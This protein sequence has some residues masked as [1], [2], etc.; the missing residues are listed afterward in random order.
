LPSGSVK[1]F[2]PQ[3]PLNTVGAFVMVK[4]KNL[5]GLSDDETLLYVR[6]ESVLLWEALLTAQF[7]GPEMR[8][9]VR[10][11]EPKSAGKGKMKSATPAP[12]NLKGRKCKA[13]A[14][15]GSK[16][17][18][19][20]SVGGGGGADE[21][22]AAPA[23]PP[24]KKGRV[25]A[26]AENSIAEGATAGLAAAPAGGGC[27][28]ADGAP[29]AAAGCGPAGGGCGAAD[30]A[31]V[32]GG[33]GGGGSKQMN[34]AVRG[35]PGTG[36][37]TEVWAWA[38]WMAKNK[39]LQVVWFH[40]DSRIHVKAVIDGAAGTITSTR[41]A[42]IT[43]IKDSEGMILVVDGV[44]K[45]DDKQIHT[46]CAA[47]QEKLSDRRFVTVSSVAIP[48]ASEH[49]NVAEI[50]EFVVG[51]WTFEQYETAC[52]DDTF[53]KIVEGNL[54][55]PEV[56][57]AEKKDLLLSKY[58]YAGGSARWMFQFNFAKWFSD[59]TK[60]FNKVDD[61]KQLFSHIGG[62]ETIFAVNHIRGATVEVVDSFGGG[63]CQETAYFFISEYAMSQL[64]KKTPAVM[65]QF[66]V[67]SYNHA[68]KIKNPAYHGWIFE[69]DIDYK[70]QTA[71]AIGTNFKFVVTCSGGSEERAVTKTVPFTSAEDL[72]PHIKDLHGTHVLW[73]KPDLWCKK[74][75]DF[76]CFFRNPDSTLN[77]VAANATVAA[78]HLV[79]LDEVNNYAR[80]LGNHDCLVSNVRFDFLVPARS[81][82]RGGDV[83]G[84]LCGWKNLLGV[85]WPNTDN[86]NRLLRNAFIVVAE[87]E[88]TH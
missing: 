31:A 16:E 87:V 47:W 32:V 83:M 20:E 67:D 84:R 40:F 77:M 82:F 64:A 38:L 48:V 52:S 66:I 11:P 69:F 45:S 19:R 41:D 50:F 25:E 43:N 24:A 80:I 70:L 36:K 61:Y 23:Q 46:S 34:I 29:A 74:A 14:E 59:F 22:D 30:A 60:F 28:S 88:Q 15:K 37:S 65:H 9:M 71:F 12:S 26:A 55:C 73:A 33:G 81:E 58:Y 5:A 57:V 63:V 72:V 49:L 44:T 51:S 85:P 42:E 18:E 78:E 4:H 1:K 76:L 21:E 3:A 79:R 68:A 17:G 27:G 54:Q 35:P 8:K 86:S 6:E 53:Y 75:F 62:D 39:N 2:S 7:G 10:V 13:S 56:K